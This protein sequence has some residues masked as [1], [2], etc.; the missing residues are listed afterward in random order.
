MRQMQGRD[1]IRFFVAP[2]LALFLGACA[3][4]FGSTVAGAV[5][6]PVPRDYDVVSFSVTVPDT[7]EVSEANVYYPGADI[8]WRGEPI[9]DR[10]AQVKA[11]FDEAI[12][13][14]VSARDGDRAVRVAVE[15]RRFHSVTELAR[16]T[17]GGVHSIRFVLTVFDAAD[18]QI[19]EGPRLVAADLDAFGGE[20]AL[21]ADRAGQTQR[22]RVVA[23]LRRTFAGLLAD[24]PNPDGGA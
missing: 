2:V 7:L 9:S 4:D 21:R 13:Q 16:Y 19:I 1:M 8:V 20:A 22:V 15:V 5:G 3:G 18:G 24:R 12:A 10:R 6:P 11:I 17:V 14:G 23:H